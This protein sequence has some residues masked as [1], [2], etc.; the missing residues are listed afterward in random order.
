MKIECICNHSGHYCRQ[1]L[2][3]IPYAQQQYDLLVMFNHFIQPNPGC[4]SSQRLVLICHTLIFITAKNSK[5][6]EQPQQSHLLHIWNSVFKR[7]WHQHVYSSVWAVT[8]EQHGLADLSKQQK[9]I[10]SQFRSLDVQDQVG[11]RILF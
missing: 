5:A 6:L 2:N 7:I 1:L 10:F 4:S 9:L 8:T 11:N 3:Y